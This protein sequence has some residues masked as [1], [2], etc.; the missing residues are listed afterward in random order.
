MTP[1]DLAGIKKVFDFK[2][3]LEYIVL[4]SHFKQRPLH[5]RLLQMVWWMYLFILKLSHNRKKAANRDTKQ[6][7]NMMIY[8][9]HLSKVII[10]LYV[11]FCH[12]LSVYFEMD[13]S[14]LITYMM[15]TFQ[16]RY[17]TGFCCS[18]SIQWPRNLFKT[19]SLTYVTETKQSTILHQT[20]SLLA[21]LWDTFGWI[22]IA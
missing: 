16:N 21:F 1:A 15:N 4:R 14:I 17:F 6:K 12:K 10:S 11:I 20:R 2:P 22:L 13:L 7:Y 18:F 5:K 3:P 19:K 8:Y 9:G